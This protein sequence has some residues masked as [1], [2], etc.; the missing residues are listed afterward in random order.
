MKNLKLL[1]ATAIL[2]AAAIAACNSPAASLVPSD[3]ASQAASPIA[4][5]EVGLTTA[6]DELDRAVAAAADD[7]GMTPEDESTL[8]DLAADLRADIEGGDLAAATT[9]AE[10]L[11]TAVEGMSDKLSAEAAPQLQ[12]AIDAIQAALAG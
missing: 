7:E 10:A 1:I 8:T 5:L 12:A 11:A 3:I 9:S 2:G 6:L 4:S